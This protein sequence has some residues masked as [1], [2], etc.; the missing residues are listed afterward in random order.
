VKIDWFAHIELQKWSR[1]G[2]SWHRNYWVDQWFKI[3]LG[4]PLAQDRHLT[5]AE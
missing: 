5:Q 3:E 1:W 2:A 4:A